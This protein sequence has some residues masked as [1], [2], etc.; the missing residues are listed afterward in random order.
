ML[1]VEVQKYLT[2]LSEKSVPAHHI[3]HPAGLVVPQAGGCTGHAVVHTVGA[4]TLGV[5]RHQPTLP[6]KGFA[7][8]MSYNPTGAYKAEF[9]MV[10]YQVL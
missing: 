1:I 3:T 5:L 6:N 4:R 8:P 2:S 10:P 9:M 7:E